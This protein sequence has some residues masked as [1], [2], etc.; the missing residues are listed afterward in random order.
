MDFDYSETSQEL[1]APL[2]AFMTEHVAPRDAE[3]TKTVDHDG[4]FPPPFI[5][6]LKAKAKAARLWNLFLPGLEPH[7]PG[8]RLSNLD[9]APCAEIM[10]RYHWAVE[11]FNCCHPDTGNM[12]T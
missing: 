11:V 5:E 1:K 4:I 7:Q 10:G 6:D 2:G 12:E 3:W 9:Y 8:T